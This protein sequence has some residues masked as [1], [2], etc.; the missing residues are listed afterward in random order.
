MIIFLSW[1]VAMV[2][3]TLAFIFGALTTR[4]KFENDIEDLIVERDSLRTV[5][6]FV[7]E[8]NLKIR[9]LLG[10]ELEADARLYSAP[11]EIDYSAH[12]QTLTD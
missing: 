4:G 8:E 5:L 7:K 3:L 1:I 2:A 12:T 11:G 10:T 6:S 9:A